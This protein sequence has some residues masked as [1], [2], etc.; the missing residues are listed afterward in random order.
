[1]LVDED[2]GADGGTDAQL[3]KAVTTGPDVCVDSV[4]AG[5]PLDFT[6]VE[7]FLPWSE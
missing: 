7:M 6:A 2:R 5:R 1:V 3:A 4:R